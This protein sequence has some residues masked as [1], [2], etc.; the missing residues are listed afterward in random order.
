M[1]RVVRKGPDCAVRLTASA[2]TA[3]ADW[4]SGCR[5][6]QSFTPDPEIAQQSAASFWRT[7]LTGRTP[8][9]LMDILLGPRARTVHGNRG[10]D[11]FNNI[12]RECERHLSTDDRVLW[13]LPPGPGI[14]ARRFRTGPCPSEHRRGLTFVRSRRT[15]D[16][17]TEDSQ[18][19]V[20]LEQR[21]PRAEPDGTGA[22]R[23]RT[24]W[25]GPHLAMSRSAARCDDA[26]TEGKRRSSGELHIAPDRG[27]DCERRRSPLHS[28]VQAAIHCTIGPVMR[29]ES[30]FGQI[31]DGFQA[32]LTPQSSGSTWF[33]Q[34]SQVFLWSEF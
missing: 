33:R 8:P 15:I 10:H 25:H 29:R 20:I 28:R 17:H 23:T 34:P 18:S 12:A 19:L 4:V 6:C 2:T 11:A 26:R 22:S 14:P 9:V 30:T 13:S 3:E 24:A 1:R 21:L 16:R 5:A 27:M 7:G 31:S 32:L